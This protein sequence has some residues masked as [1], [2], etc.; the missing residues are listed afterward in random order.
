MLKDKSTYIYDDNAS[1][2][3]LTIEHL[4]SRIRNIHVTASSLALQPEA[5]ESAFARLTTGLSV[6]A[7]ALLKPSEPGQFTLAKTY[8]NSSFAE[9]V[10]GMLGWN[11][12]R[13]E[14]NELIV[15]AEQS[16]VLPIGGRTTDAQGNPLG[17]LALLKLDPVL[18]GS[19]SKDQNVYL[20]DSLGNIILS[21][22]PPDST[23]RTEIAEF[24][25]SL[26]PKDKN[27]IAKEWSHGGSKYI[28]TYRRF[29]AGQ[30][31]LV[32]ITP[33][34]VAYEA[35]QQLKD[36]YVVVGLAILLFAIG[37][38]LV[39]IKTITRRLLELW[40]AT[41]KV[42]EGD[43]TVRVQAD[44][45]V[46]DELSGLANSFNTMAEKIDDLIKQTAD[47]ARMEKELETAKLV[48]S[49]FYPSKN[50][51]HGSFQLA[52][53]LISASECGGDWWHYTVVGDWLVVVMGDVTGHGVSAAL[54]TA[55]AHTAFSIM[56]DLYRKQLKDSTI[57]PW[58]RVIVDGLNKAICVSGGGES[59]MTFVISVI[60]LKTGIAL[61]T[62]TGHR[63][64][65][66]YRKSD[67]PADDVRKTFRP[68]VSPLLMSLG[69][70]PKL[71][72]IITRFELKPGDVILWYTDGLIECINPDG[73]TRS[74]VVMMESI[75]QMADQQEGDV[76]VICDGIMQ[77][78]L[79][80]VGPGTAR[81][82]DDITVVVGNFK[83]AA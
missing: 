65:Y 34:K 8:G 62:N 75:R 74:K 27:A 39:F 14:E 18:L 6:E 83:K 35:A 9:T 16:G 70:K 69:E 71:D 1:R 59:T 76:K 20:L 4:S 11:P 63:P 47:K 78:T 49:I 44:P 73:K 3:G 25:K 68:L 28:A 50:F 38:S 58:I 23:R 60:N 48:Q 17:Y 41:K 36:R 21:N 26:P 54:V 2:L 72:I 10:F 33:Q 24:I 22:S 46:T 53:R 81:L 7:L 52:G 12:K 55:A 51:D 79:S 29:L 30:L 37:F 43:F 56:V 67:N 42:S 45:V 31:S 13:L 40:H 80:F 32:S 19:P 57:E 64:P 15:G 61:S 82:D 5:G 77:E 66:V